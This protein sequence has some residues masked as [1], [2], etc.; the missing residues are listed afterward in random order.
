MIS[1]DNLSR[2]D[3]TLFV[4]RTAIAA[5]VVGSEALAATELPPGLY[6]PSTDHL[7]HALMDAGPFRILPADCPTDYIRASTGPFQPLFFPAPQFA[8][9]RRLVE[10]LLGGTPAVQ[11][12]AGWIDLR[13]SEAAAIRQAALRL[14]PLQRI[15]AVAYFGPAQ[16]ANIEASEPETVCHAGLEWLE[17]SATSRYAR[18]FLSLEESAQLTL[19][20]SISDDNHPDIRAN[21]GTRLF[22]YLKSEA[23]RGFYTSQL[24]LK[25]L[26]FKGNAFYARSPGCTVK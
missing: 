2:R 12:I 21:A 10:L 4:T 26:D 7:G 5:G 24:G 25:E 11:E 6:T 17:D 3:W 14:D 15:L 9:I 22:A 20:A 16:V 13:V 1:D 19:L 23:I 8:V 18:S